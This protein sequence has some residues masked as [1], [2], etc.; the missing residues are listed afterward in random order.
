[1]APSWASWAHFSFISVVLAV[2][3]V[4][5]MDVTP[6]DDLLVL[7]FIKK[8]ERNKNDYNR[9]ADELSYVDCEYCF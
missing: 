9:E 6:L 3:S 1:M 5:L 4:E 2:I 7:P 8:G